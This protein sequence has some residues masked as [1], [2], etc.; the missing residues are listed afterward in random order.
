DEGSATAETCVRACDEV[1]ALA[2]YKRCHADGRDQHGECEYHFSHCF[3]FRNKSCLPST[4]EGPA[5]RTGKLP[6]GN[7]RFAWATRVVSFHCEWCLPVTCPHEPVPDVN[8]NRLLSEVGISMRGAPNT[9]NGRNS[10]LCAA[11]IR[12]GHQPR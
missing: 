2:P 5:H 1:R 6:P 4:P 3:P 9:V 12:G 11:P 10:W 8:R 7:V